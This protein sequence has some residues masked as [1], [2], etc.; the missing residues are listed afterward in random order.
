MPGPL[1]AGAF[2]TSPDEK[3]HTA[4]ND[5]A[6][7]LSDRS[8]NHGPIWTCRK[9]LSGVERGIFVMRV[10]NAQNGMDGNALLGPYR[11][12]IPT[13]PNQDM[14]PGGRDATGWVSR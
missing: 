6:A 12:T 5:S 2:I 9:Y 4:Q 8:L 10:I 13:V 1:S 14:I 11:L 7:A 3:I